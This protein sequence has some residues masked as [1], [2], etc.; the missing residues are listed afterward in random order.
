MKIVLEKALEAPTGAEGDAVSPA[1]IGDA[2]GGGVE[3]GRTSAGPL[4]PTAAAGFPCGGCE[5]CSRGIF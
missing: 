5:G 4:Q 1:G 2:G 3:G